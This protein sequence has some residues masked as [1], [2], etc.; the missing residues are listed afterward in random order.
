[1]HNHIYYSK[2]FN[3]CYVFESFHCNFFETLWLISNLDTGKA[4][5]EFAK[6]G[7]SVRDAVSSQ[8]DIGNEIRPKN[9]FV[10]YIIRIF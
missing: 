7:I 9:M 10:E 5:I 1:M 8:Y 4:D 2:S 6:T 3:L